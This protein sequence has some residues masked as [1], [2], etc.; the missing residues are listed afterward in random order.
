MSEFQRPRRLRRTATLQLRL[1]NCE[2]GDQESAN[3][4]RVLEF[5]VLVGPASE[6][7]NP[8]IWDVEMKAVTYLG[9]HGCEN[10]RKTISDSTVCG[11]SLLVSSPIQS[12]KQ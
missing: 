7:N 1:D 2:A 4:N 10:S 12:Q 5:Q 8:G 6:P 9:S 11:V 3:I